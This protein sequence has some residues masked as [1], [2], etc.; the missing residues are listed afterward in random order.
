MKR[1]SKYKASKLSWLGEIPD[2]W[3]EWK[4]SRLFNKITSGTTPK[5]GTPEYYE[6]GTIPWINT[7]DLNDSYLFDCKNYITEKA[8]KDH[9][10]LKICDVDTLII[11]MYGA[12]IGKTAITKF[13]A[14]TNQA[15]CN[16]SESNIVD[17]KFAYYWFLASKEDIINLSYGGGQP[18]ISQDVIKTL[19]ISIPSQSE[20]LTIVNFLDYKTNQIDKFIANRQKQIELLKEQ[21]AGIINKAVTKGINPKSKMKNS[22]IEWIGNIPEHW[23]IGKTRRVLD[24]LTDFTAN[25]SFADLAKNV[26]YLDTPDFSR[27]IRLTDLREDL[28]NDGIY[29]NEDAHKFLSKSELF[30]GEILMANVGAYAGYV[31]LVPKIDFTAT[32]GP[33]MLMLKF[34]KKRISNQ[35]AYTLLNSDCYNKLLMN[36]AL[37]SAQPKLNKEDIRSIDLIFPPTLEEQNEILNHINEETLNVDDLISKY[38][39]QIDLMQ[40][41]R[42][43]LISQAVTGKIDVRDWKPKI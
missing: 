4:V 32:L 12:T 27:L 25:G 39:K 16:L 37:S 34:D 30:G 35:Y 8:F 42:I 15:C 1:Y 3:V 7:G 10:T 17:T 9:S 21:K 43:A 36:K 2:E 41:Y 33:N 13:K 40:E 28:K 11:A 31:C 14:C 18:N 23:M 24:I 38:Q 19:K 5:A 29:V 20:Q 26:K 22:S 6:N